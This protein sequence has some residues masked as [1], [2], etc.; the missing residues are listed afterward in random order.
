M[1]CCKHELFTAST[2]HYQYGATLPQPYTQIVCPLGRR[3]YD[4]LFK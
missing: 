2:D 1:P 4:D 3:F